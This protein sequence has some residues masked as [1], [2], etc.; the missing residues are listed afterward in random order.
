MMIKED[1]YIV[2]EDEVEWVLDRQTDEYLS[3]ED[4]CNKLND[5]EDSMGEVGSFLRDFDRL[6]DKAN[7]K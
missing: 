2:I 7:K 5:Y 6:L 3:L 1:R 4:A